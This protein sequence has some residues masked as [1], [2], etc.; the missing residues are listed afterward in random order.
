MRYAEVCAAKVVMTGFLSRQA[1]EDLSHG[2]DI[3]F[4][5]AL[6]DALVLDGKLASGHAMHTN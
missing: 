4:H 3:L 2:A 5:L 6:L 1:G